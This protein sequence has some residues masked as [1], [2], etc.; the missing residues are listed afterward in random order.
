MKKILILSLLFIS[1]LS[2]QQ[3]YYTYS[4]LKGLEDQSNNTHLFYRLFYYKLVG[5]PF[6]TVQSNSIYRYDPITNTETFFLFDGSLLPDNYKSVED[7][8]FWENDFDRYIYVSTYVSTEGFPQVYRYDQMDPIFAPDIWGS[9]RNI[10]LSRQD[11][12][13]IIVSF[14]SSPYNNFK[15]TD[16][17][18][19]WDTLANGYEILSVS[20]FN[21]NI[22]FAS[23]WPTLFKSTDGGISFNIVDTGRIYSNNFIYDTDETHIFAL[24][25]R[26]GNHL[27]VSNDIGNAFSW[28]EK[29]FS[30][31]SI[32][33]SVDYSQSGSIYLA[34]GRYIYHS[35]DYG[36]T[37]SDYKVLDR[38]I[39][40]IYKKPAS[41]KLYAATKYDLYEITPST[42]VSIKHLPVDP[43]ILNWY[44]LK[45]GNKW[46]YENSIEA[47]KYR[48]SI[49]VIK[50]TLIQGKKYF[51]EKYLSNE[52][53][54]YFYERIDSSD[55]KVYR[56][57][58][59]SDVVYYD[60]T[61]DVGDTVLFD[62]GN[63]YEY[64]WVLENQQSFNEF[65]ISSTLR[66]FNVLLYGSGYRLYSFVKD[67]GLYKDEGGEVLY[68]QSLLKGFIKDGIVYGDTSLV[69]VDVRDP[70]K[71]PT[72]FFLF[73]NYPNPFNPTTNI[74]FRIAN[75]GFVTLRVYDVL[76]R[77]VATLVNE[78]KQP[79]EYEVEF[80][81]ASGIKNL[82]SGIY[83]YKLQAGS[84]SSTKK[85]I[86]LK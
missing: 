27:M 36:E 31:N 49:E 38:K 84:Y 70:K 48:N 55:G 50:D 20:P 82:A 60:F 85:M 54:N 43:E 53:T 25:N 64:G 42:I 33:I 57:I 34:D 16:W 75:F 69:T 37:F 13:K 74:G 83:F 46:V 29:Y 24:D 15:S 26:L 51:K 1:N 2:A 19:N 63:E 71:V 11:T 14:F 5:P 77:E 58:G 86:Y 6:G 28:E 39:V 47:D 30:S 7:Y 68:T 18:N 52:T 32:F 73:Q 61:A 56:R 45:T 76:G 9:G 44:P 40:G 17:G 22:I 12:N 79:G 3:Y 72:E 67:I 23:Q 41:D 62:R 80:N 8:D 78:E 10:E 21:D 66:F 81:P 59:D 4:E 35:S 65:G